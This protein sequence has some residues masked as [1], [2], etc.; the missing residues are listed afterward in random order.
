M[1][2]NDMNAGLTNEEMAK[3]F[4]EW[5]ATELKSYLISITIDILRKKDCDIEGLAPQ[6]GYLVD[7]M[8]V[9][10][11]TEKSIATPTIAT[12]L[13]QRFIAADKDF[14]MTA[15]VFAG[16]KFDWSKIQRDQLVADVKSALYCSKIC[17]YAQGMNLIKKA[18]EEFGWGINLAECARIWEGGCI[19]Q[20]KF[21]DDIRNAFE[22]DP[23]L[24]SIIFAP[25]FRDALIKNQSGWRRIVT[26][27]I[28]SGITC[29][30]FAES[31]AYFD[32]SRRQKLPANLIQSQRD[33]FGGHTFERVDQPR[34]KFFHCRW[35]ENHA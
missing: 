7:K 22:A 29:P 33:Y 1:V 25:L 12:S 14:R 31:L 32:T 19:I 16:P 11:S 15:K 20:A 13:Y 24:S 30:A 10:E 2:H 3:V 23:K 4:E 34:D 6:E 18:S 5:N 9:K 26:L 27:S 17:S 21:L 28:A 8:T 35:T